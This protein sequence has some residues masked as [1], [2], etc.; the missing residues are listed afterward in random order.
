MKITVSRNELKGVLKL[1]SKVAKNNQNVPVLGCVLV[2][3]KNGSVIVTATNLDTYIWREILH[4]HIENEGSIAIPAGALTRIVGL[5]GSDQ[6]TIETS[7]EQTI[8][9][10][11]KS[12]YK[13]LS[14]SASAYPP[15]P[16]NKAERYLDISSSQFNAA[17][18][19]VIYAASK[20]EN[21]SVLMGVLLKTNN[22]GCFEI[23]ATDTHR[24]A[25]NKIEVKDAPEFEVVAPS[26][27]LDIVKGLNGDLNIS[28]DAH[29]L[30]V[31]NNTTCIMSRLLDGK[32]PDYQKVLVHEAKTVMHGCKAELLKAINR[33]GVV[34]KHSAN[35]VKM[36]I[37][38]G[39]LVLT[40]E[41]PEVGTAREIVKIQHDGIIETAC[42]YE[43]LCDAISHM[44]S[45]EVTISFMSS[46]QPM[47]VSAQGINETTIVMPMQI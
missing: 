32:Y 16:E 31:R 35:K 25:Y 40:A 37:K 46:L 19:P 7:E 9:K 3:A 2:E 38:E 21:R 24:L 1:L 39:E 34:A 30:C 4:P 23:V 20:E 18:E 28:V 27:A 17:L 29:Q 11:G 5:L 26:N 45:D 13:L 33:V 36:S 22:T 6:V 43:Y 15:V 8:I 44:N 14:M 41:A 42:N 10:S 47:K 12:K